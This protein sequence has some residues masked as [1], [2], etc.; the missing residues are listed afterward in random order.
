MAI[1]AKFSGKVA[2]GNIAAATEAF[3]TV[4]ARVESAR[5]EVTH[6]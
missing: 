2:A 1:N 6:A 3:E 5:K 4:L